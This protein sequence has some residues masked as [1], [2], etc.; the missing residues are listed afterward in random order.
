MATY[1]STEY[2]TATAGTGVKNAPTTWNGVTY[3]YARFTGQ[4]LSSS[5]TVQVMT[6]PSGV[7][8]MPQ[9]MVIISDLEASAAVNVGYAVHTTQSTG[10]AVAVDVDAFIS[11]LAAASARTVTNFHESTTHDTG[12]VTTGELILTFGLSAGTSLA[13]DTFDFH[14]MYADPN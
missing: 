10:A 9:S 8:I 5:D 1:K 12:Y 13:G 2:T 7:R 6:I 11:A 4:A 14:I 3:R